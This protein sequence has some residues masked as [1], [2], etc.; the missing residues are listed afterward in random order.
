MISPCREYEL[1]HHV[2]QVCDA[3]TAV[4]EELNDDNNNNDDDDDEGRDSPAT[5]GAQESGYGSLG[6]RD[7]TDT[8]DIDNEEE[9]H[10]ARDKVVN[11]N[12]F[13]MPPKIIAASAH[14]FKEK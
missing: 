5:T 9:F 3:A 11:I 13:P 4:R 7:T 1:Q 8:D 14:A 12:N 2:V 6:Y 10:T